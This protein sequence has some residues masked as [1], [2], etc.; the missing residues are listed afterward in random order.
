MLLSDGDAQLGVL[1]MLLDGV[2]Q[3]DLLLVL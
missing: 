3:D 2:A 1:G